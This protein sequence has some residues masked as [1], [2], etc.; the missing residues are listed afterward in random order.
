MPFKD[1][2][3]ERF[4]YLVVESW[5]ATY[6]E[7]IQVAAGETIELDGR[8]D[9][10]DGHTWLWAKS[11]DGKEGW[12]PDCIISETGPIAATENYTAME[13]TCQEGQTLTAQ[14]NLHGWVFCSNGE[15]QKGWVPKRNLS[16]I[17]RS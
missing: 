16:K 8:T 3:I 17:N 13:L 12:V 1:N 2:E 5:T 15:G 6:P 4:D 10:W 11:R 7:P 14:R 9:V